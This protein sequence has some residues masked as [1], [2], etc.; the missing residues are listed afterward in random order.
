MRDYIY[1]SK[2]GVLGGFALFF[3]FFITAFY[4]QING[5]TLME[6]MTIFL[7]CTLYYFSI[8]IFLGTWGFNKYIRETVNIQRSFGKRFLLI[9]IFAVVCFL[10]Y[11]ILD[12]LYFLLDDSLSVEFAGCLKKMPDSPDYVDDFSEYPFS[13]IAI[14]TP[15]GFLG[16]FVTMLLVKKDGQL[17]KNKSEEY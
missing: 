5:L 16:V 4:L 6:A 11:S 15:L 10:V 17:I 9:T 13:Y 8:I 12:G 2:L 7:I 1:S 3:L 14:S